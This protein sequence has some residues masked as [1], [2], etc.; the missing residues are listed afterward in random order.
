[1]INSIIQNNLIKIQ[2]N[3]S[4]QEKKQQRIYDLLNAERKSKC[5]CL[6]ETKQRRK[7][8]SQKKSFG[9]Q[10]GKVR[11]E[12]KTLRMLFIFSHSDD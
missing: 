11:I 10:K 6:Q 2:R 1:M 8:I 4:D 5:L 7:K 3:M 12:Q 9:K